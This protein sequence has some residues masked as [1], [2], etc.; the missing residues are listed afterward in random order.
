MSFKLGAGT[1]APGTSQRWWYRLAGGSDFG[2]QYC[3]A[4]LHPLDLGVLQVNNQAK[5]RWTDGT[6]YFVTVTNIGPMTVGFDLI[7][8]GLT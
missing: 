1:L 6:T 2:A 3:M 7:G 4:D 5:E 8:G